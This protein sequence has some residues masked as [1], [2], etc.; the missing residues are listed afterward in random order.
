MGYSLNTPPP[1]GEIDVKQAMPDSN[2]EHWLHGLEV[3]VAPL[4]RAHRVSRHLCWRY[5][6]PQQFIEEPV[7]RFFDC[8]EIVAALGSKPPM[9]DQRL[10][11][12]LAQ[13]DHHTAQALL[14]ALAMA[15]HA[16]CAWRAWLLSRRHGWLR[17][18]TP[19]NRS[20]AVSI[21]LPAKPIAWIGSSAADATAPS[22]P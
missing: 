22:S 9:S 8:R 5:V 20:S 11:L 12:A 10:N 2:F 6:L 4:E 19:A 16:Q 1:A 21:S 15:G 13:L 18:H 3:R 17:R 7:Q 14:L